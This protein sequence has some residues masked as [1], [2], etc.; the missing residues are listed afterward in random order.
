MR[1]PLHILTVTLILIAWLP[2]LSAA[3]PASYSLRAVD[4]VT[5]AKDQPGNDCWSYA[6]VGAFE[7]NLLKQG[8]VQSPTAT[9][10]DLSENHMMLY[11]ANPN[12]AQNLG[13]GGVASDATAYLARGQGMLLQ[14]A[15]SGSSPTAWQTLAWLQSEAIELTKGTSEDIVVHRN[16]IK[17]ALRRYGAIYGSVYWMDNAYNSTTKVFYGAN[18]NLGGGTVGG[19]AI[20]IV[21]WDDAQTTPAPNPGAWLCRN[22]WG[23]G[24]GDNGYFWVAYEN[25]ENPV[26]KSAAFVGRAPTGY[27][28]TLQYQ[29]KNPGWTF[30]AGAGSKTTIAARFSQ[31]SAGTL[32]AVGFWT[33]QSNA[34][35]TIRVHS[36]WGT[37][38]PGTVVHTQTATYA[39]PG[40]HLLPLT[41]PYA[42]TANQEWV[43]SVEAPDGFSQAAEFTSPGS[44]KTYRSFD[45][46]NGTDGTWTDL[47]DFGAAAAIKAILVDSA[48]WDITPPTWASGWPKI[49]NP[50]TTT[51]DLCAKSTETGMA[52]YVVLASGSTAPSSEQV[53]TGNDADGN[54][55]LLAGRLALTADTEATTT[56][57]APASGTRY[58]VYVVAQDGIPNVTSATRLEAL[59]G[60]PLELWRNTYWNITTDTGNAANTADPDGDGMANL[61]EYAMG[62]AP[63]SSASRPNL[64]CQIS[65]SKLQI[66]FTPQVITGLTYIVQA[67]SDL[68]DWSDQTDITASLTVGTPTTHTDSVALGAGTKRFLRLKVSQ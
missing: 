3:E 54:P 63:D 55:A 6:A 50:T 48:T 56:L 4:L 1:P 12:T 33:K 5:S 41:T 19:H 23:T 28:S 42:F 66:T 11:A 60:T 52:F 35:F 2:R 21:G 29:F 34:T 40:Y 17:A 44:N 30:S 10:V 16:R 20:L 32:G 64:T 62:S 14:A 68:S 65:D 37:N 9:S 61:L 25:Y 59:A 58:D 15:G 27:S 47:N 45:A 38:A 18:N 57:T 24:W 46:T 67:S 7:S 49:A 51:F 39:D 22:S 43:I 53:R 8:L 31:T 26:A 13:T 36:G